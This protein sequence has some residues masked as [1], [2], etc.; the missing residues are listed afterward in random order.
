MID[1]IILLGVDEDEVEGAGEG[2]DGLPG[3]ADDDSRDTLQ[4]GIG[5]V[6]I[7]LRRAL[8]E[9]L[10]ACYLAAVLP[11]R[12]GQPDGGDAVR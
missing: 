11:R 1:I 6:A 10:G 2:S 8:R 9:D 4:P 12:R 3:I 5:E 7:R